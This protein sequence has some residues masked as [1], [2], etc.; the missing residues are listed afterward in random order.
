MIIN[1][2]LVCTSQGGSTGPG[3]GPV[4]APA[5]VGVH[6]VAFTNLQCVGPGLTYL[7]SHPTSS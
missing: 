5:I 4:L 1:Y 2:K 7:S 3:A 6:L